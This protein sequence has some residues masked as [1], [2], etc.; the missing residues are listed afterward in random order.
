MNAWGYFLA[1]LNPFRPDPI[2]LLRKEM[3]LDVQR[4]RAN[5]EAIF[6][7]V[8]PQ[9]ELGVPKSCIWKGNFPSV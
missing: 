5:R 2:K 6:E 9:I 8:A 3:E 4:L 1:T 7:A